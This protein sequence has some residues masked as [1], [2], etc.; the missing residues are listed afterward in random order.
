[1]AT[2]CFQCV[3]FFGMKNKET[4]DYYLIKLK[5]GRKGYFLGFEF[6]FIKNFHVIL[7]LPDSN[8]SKIFTSF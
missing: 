4:R 1:M 8:L 5:F 7:A 6:K 2:F 3:T